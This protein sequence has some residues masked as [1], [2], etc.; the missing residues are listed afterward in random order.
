VC[1]EWNRVCGG[2][3]QNKFGSVGVFLD[4]PYAVKD[5]D[6]GVYHKDSVSVAHAV[7]QWCMERGSEKDYRIVLAGYEEHEELLEHGWAKEGWKTQGGYS[8]TARKGAETQGKANSKREVL[9]F[10]PHCFNM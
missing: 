5:R 7:W 4:P 10:S 2:N 1:G 6:A 8:A 3:W 9:Y